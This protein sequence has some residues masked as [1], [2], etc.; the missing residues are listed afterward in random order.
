VERE[1]LGT[2]VIGV[3]AEQ[4][5]AGRGERG[6]RDSSLGEEG[7]WVRHLWIAGRW[8]V[9]EGGF[10]GLESWSGSSVK[11]CACCFDLYLCPGLSE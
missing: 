5:S 4:K 11:M 7:R 3:G 1:V 6:R 10:W 9:A 2:G 8:S